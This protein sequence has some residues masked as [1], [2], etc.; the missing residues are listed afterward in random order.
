MVGTTHYWNKLK[1][2]FFAGFRKGFNYSGRA[3][4]GN[5]GVKHLGANWNAPCRRDR[6][7][8]CL[9]LLHHVVTPFEIGVANVGT[10][11]NPAGNAVDGAG[12]Y[13]ADSDRRYCVDG[14]A[15]SRGILDGQNQFGCGAE[16]IAPV[17]HQNSACMPACTLDRD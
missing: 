9:Y 13:F 12:K 3:I 11:T 6:L 15:V 7:T 10:E 2:V 14:S 1:S 4:G 16:G 5:I 17:R 8:C